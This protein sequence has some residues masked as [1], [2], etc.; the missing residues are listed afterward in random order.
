MQKYLFEKVTKLDK[1]D[2]NPYDLNSYSKSIRSNEI[3]TSTL[4]KIT[5]SSISSTIRR[6]INL[7]DTLKK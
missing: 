7:S 4:A 2:K 6:T 3:K 5:N 1:S